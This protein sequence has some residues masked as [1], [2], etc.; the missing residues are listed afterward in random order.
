M[1]HKAVVS[2]PAEQTAFPLIDSIDPQGFVM[3]RLF[4]DATRYMEGHHVK[5]GVCAHSF[6]TDVGHI[7]P[8]LSVSRT[9]LVLMLL[10]G[11]KSVHLS[12]CFGFN[13]NLDMDSA[14]LRSLDYQ[15]LNISVLQDV[16]CL[17]RDTSKVIMVDCK[18][19]SFQLQPFNGLALT[20]W[21]GNSD[22]RALYDLANFLKSKS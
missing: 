3:Y 22:D 5:V 14:P 13:L 18:R 6:R 16:S 21:D 19:E 4:R 20:K 12:V 2:V 10:S 1:V 11:F 17:N 7:G 8:Q 15:H 9:A